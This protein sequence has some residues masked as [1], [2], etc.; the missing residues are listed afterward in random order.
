MV[1]AG[2]PSGLLLCGNSKG[3]VREAEAL[4]LI[5]ENDL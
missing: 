3:I 4:P 1:W 5:I 2:M